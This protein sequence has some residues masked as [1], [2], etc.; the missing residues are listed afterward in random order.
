M[1]K[2]TSEPKFVMVVEIDEKRKRQLKKLFDQTN[3]ELEMSMY[4]NDAACRKFDEKWLTKH[5]VEIDLDNKKNPTSEG[6]SIHELDRK[7]S[8]SACKE[9]IVAYLNLNHAGVQMPWSS[10]EV[11]ADAYEEASRRLSRRLV[12]R[13]VFIWVLRLMLYATFITAQKLAADAKLSE[14][15]ITEFSR[16][17]VA[18][19]VFAYRKCFKEFIKAKLTNAIDC[20]CGKCNN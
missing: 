14:A 20:H 8:H 16:N 9:L 1:S 12:N 19:R 10:V 4:F 7:E 6:R 15:D 11:F 5:V 17:P 13:S 18:K 2:A 3:Y